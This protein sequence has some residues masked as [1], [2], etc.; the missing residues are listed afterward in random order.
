MRAF[1]FWLPVLLALT[2][3]SNAIAGYDSQS[4]SIWNQSDESNP[5]IIDHSLFDGFLKTYVVTNHPSGINRFRYADVSRADGKKLDT[6]IKQ[7]ISLDPRKYRKQVQK[8]YWLNLY[9]ALTL[10]ALLKKYPLKSVDSN[11]LSQRVKVAGVKLETHDIGNRILRPIWNDYKVVFGMSCASM[12]C[13]AIQSQAF[14]ASNTEDLLKASAREF[15]NHPRGLVVNRQE[16]QASKIFDWYRDDFG[17]DDSRL[18]K[19]FAHYADDSKAL[20]ILG[21]SSRIQYRLDDR[22]NS[23]ETA[24]PL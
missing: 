21:F 1:K 20:Y 16:M 23:P 24:W 10:Q 5:S 7:I 17:A 13:P 11:K 14:T 4:W 22:L 12:G 19:L 3:A 9:N 18:M 6:Y 8:A 2:Y 15:I